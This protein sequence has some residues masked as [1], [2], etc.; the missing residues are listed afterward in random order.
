MDLVN[1][2]STKE[3]IALIQNMIECEDLAI[4]L[5]GTLYEGDALSCNSHIAG[6]IVINIKG[7]RL[8]NV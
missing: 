4:S 8:L 7:E 5:G 1:K 2:L 3:K 6:Q